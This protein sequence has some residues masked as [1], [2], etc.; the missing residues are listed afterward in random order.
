MDDGVVSTMYRR[1]SRHFEDYS[2]VFLYTPMRFGMGCL[3]CF[4]SGVNPSAVLASIKDIGNVVRGR[5]RHLKVR[6][7]FVKN[8]PVTNSRG[9]KFRTSDSHL[10]RGTCCVVAPNNRITLR[11]LASFARVVSSLNTVPVILADR[12]RSFVATKID[13]LPRVVTSTLMGLI[14]VLSD[15]RRCVGAVTTKN[16]HSVAHVTSSSPVV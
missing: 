14:G 15:S 2:C 1:R 12:R 9:A 16:F 10:V 7:H 6:S 4:G 5:M 3:R 8:R 11:H 13:R